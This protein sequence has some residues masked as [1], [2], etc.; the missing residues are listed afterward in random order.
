MSNFIMRRIEIKRENDIRGERVRQDIEDLGLSSGK[1]EVL[2]VYL[3]YGDIT[4]EEFLRIVEVVTDPVS[5]EW[6]VFKFAKNTKIIEVALNPGVMDPVAIDTLDVIE[7]IGIEIDGVKTLKKYVFYDTDDKTVNLAKERVLLNPLI[8]HIVMGKET[9]EMVKPGKKRTPTVNVSS[10]TEKEL[11]DLSESMGLFLNKEEMKDI[12]HYFSKEG[13]APTIAELE[14]F[15]ILWSEHCSH[16]TMRGNVKIRN[17]KFEIRNLLKSTVM[18]VTEDLKKPWVISAF[19]DNAGIVEFNDEYAVCFKV[20]THNHPSALEPFGGAA[21]GVGG[22]V[23][24]ILG[25]GLGAKPIANVDV[26][27]VGDPDTSYSSLP[28]GVLHPRRILRGIV[29][30]VGDYGNK[31]GIP[32]VNGSVTYHKDY[33]ANPLV[34]CGCVGIIPKASCQKKVNT[35]D[36][37]ILVGGRTGRD[38]I[39]G[40]TFSS[41]VMDEN[42][43]Q[44]FSSAVQIGDP[45]RE[46]NLLD[47]ILS[48]RD[49]ELYSSITDCGAGGICT[50][51]SELAEGIGAKVQLENVPLKYKGLSP[52]EIWISESQ[53]RMVLSAPEEKLDELKKIFDECESELTV[54]GKFVKTDRIVV[55]YKKEKICDIDLDFLLHGMP[56]TAKTAIIPVTMGNR[57]E[58]PENLDIESIFESMLSHPDIASKEW[59]VRQYDHEVQGGTVIKPLLADAAVIKPLFIKG[60]KGIVIGHGLAPFYEDVY[61]NALSSLDEAVRNLC[62]VGGDPSH[63][64]L[65]DNF[66]WGS[67]EDPVNMGKLVRACEALYN[68][69][70]AYKMPFISGKDS[71]YNE[72]ESDREKQSVLPTIL[73]S[74]IS[75]IEDARKGITQSIKIPGDPIYIIGCTYPELGSSLLYRLLKIQDGEEP[76]LHPK[77]AIE[78]YRKLHIAI[79]KDVILSCH[80]CSEGGIGIAISEMCF[81]TGLGM[82]LSLDN[83]PVSGVKDPIAILFSESNSRFIV[84]IKREKKKEFE[85]IMSEMPFGKVGEVISSRS[86]VIE[87]LINI[88]VERL[89]NIWKSRGL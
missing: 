29:S 68:V 64:A 83:V 74:G 34:Y 41:G 67:P 75:F 20:E 76:F 63:I 35:N 80:D 17:S 39:H 77:E 56:K 73:I 87:N 5:E 86:L 47:A 23:R 15:G 46:K 59:I 49:K 36:L 12:S 30:G 45:L 88:P 78:L 65:L 61:K 40:A 85:E 9:L 22:V 72:F 8:Q 42:T 81:G 21:T 84:E 69:A 60:N 37:I 14:T 71:L 70:S 31:L 16:K 3:I 19:K 28:E 79:K 50:A 18:K 27:C 89:E 25:C 48:T 33:T 26:F 62:A 32:T 10:L 6:G 38:G 7:K 66:S 58:V 44:E 57:E 2:D 55:S 24:D 4:D 52:T 51:V 11:L 82:K 53:E 1:V 13:R 43:Q 54:I